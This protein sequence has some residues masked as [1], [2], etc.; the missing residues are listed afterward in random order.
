MSISEHE[1]KKGPL[2]A[3]NG[4]VTSRI[5][6]YETPAPSDKRRTR[7]P[8]KTLLPG[9]ARIALDNTR[10]V[11]GTAR[12]PRQKTSLQSHHDRR[13]LCQQEDQL[14]G[15]K[16]ASSRGKPSSP[17]GRQ[18]ARLYLISIPAAPAAKSADSAPTRTL[19]P[20]LKAE[21]GS[22]SWPPPPSSAHC[23]AFSVHLSAAVLRSRI[24]D[25]PSQLTVLLLSPRRFKV[26]PLPGL[27]FQ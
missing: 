16:H 6:G 18:R 23:L 5:L 8:R 1:I 10:R 17:P 14:A 20:R 13:I 4:N 2:L 27:W 7:P 22:P 26:N 9:V 3:V 24:N 15:L 21:P 12:F 11:V 25:L 19:K